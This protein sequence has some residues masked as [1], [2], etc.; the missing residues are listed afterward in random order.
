M[1]LKNIKFSDWSQ[2]IEVE[3][4]PMLKPLS[5]ETQREI[6]EAFVRAKRSARCWKLRGYSE[7][8]TSLENWQSLMHFLL[9][10]TTESD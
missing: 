4:C 10:T 9:G 7:E 2:M 6:A 5:E 1:V 3:L 8:E